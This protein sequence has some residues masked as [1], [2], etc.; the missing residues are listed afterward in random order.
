MRQLTPLWPILA[1]L[2]LVA[3]APGPGVAAGPLDA[4]AIDRSASSLTFTATQT[5]AFVNGRFPV[6][7][8]KIVLDPAALAG[9]RID[10]GI[11]MPAVTAGNQDVDS[12]MKG[13]SFFDVGKF[14]EARFVA[15]TVVAAGGGRYEARGK[16]TIRDVTR[17]VVLPF[18]LAIAD[19]PAQPGALRATARGKLIIKRLD[20]GV[21]RNEWAGTGQVANEVAIELNV[22]A[23][24]PR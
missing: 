24:R 11:E 18:T 4:W 5:G 21:G 6:W 19:N 22:V 20:Y 7:S 16:L 23:S 12:L 17:D 8:G 3:P 13:A 1:A 10:I 2:L 9:A 14:P 15:G